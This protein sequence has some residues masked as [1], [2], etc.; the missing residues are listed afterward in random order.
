MSHAASL[1]NRNVRMNRIYRN[2]NS[3]TVVKYL[4]LAA[5]SL[6]F[7]SI[8][9][10]KAGL[11][12]SLFLILA[13]TAIKFFNK[14]KILHGRPEIYRYSCYLITVYLAGLTLSLIPSFELHDILWFARKGAFLLIIPLF[15]LSLS[16]DKSI[17]LFLSLLG[18]LVSIIYSIPLFSQQSLDQRVSSFWDVG[19]WSEIL[20]YSIAILIPTLHHRERNKLT[21]RT[22]I[23][24]LCTVCLCFIS[25]LITGSRGPLLFLFIAIFIYYSLSQRKLLII[26]ISFSLLFLLLIHLIPELNPI[27]D[28]IKSI[29]A[30]NNNSNNARLLMWK[31]GIEF[32]KHNIDNNFVLFLFGTGDR[33]IENLLISFI[34]TIG[35]IDNMQASVGYQISFNDFHNAYLDTLIKTGAI[36]FTLYISTIGYTAHILI[37]YIK[38]GVT[39]AWSGLTMLITQLGIGLVYSNGME[40]QTIIFYL[41]MALILVNCISASEHEEKTSND[42]QN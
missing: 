20:A 27:Y 39:L 17:A 36:F 12:I 1:I 3:N 34:K 37:K 13:A 29:I 38:N 4:S 33:N 14:N 2:L 42:F 35:S 5:I 41:M 9:T 22:S 23:L 15:S 28:R 24:L 21:Q 32:I 30:S 16:K 6:A 31:N 26:F 11:S 19:R 40:Y 10:S 7:T 18:L 25:L 8:Y